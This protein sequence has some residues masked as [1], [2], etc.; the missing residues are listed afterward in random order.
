MRF[1]DNNST[2]GEYD[3]KRYY[4]DTLQ[5]YLDDDGASG[6]GTIFNEFD[7]TLQTLSTNSSSADAK[8]QFIEQQ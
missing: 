8:A 5:Q 2:L 3:I 6:F 4:T 7:A 1:R